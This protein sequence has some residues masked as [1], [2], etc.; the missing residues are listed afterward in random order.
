MTLGE[1]IDVKTFTRKQVEK[2]QVP[3][4]RSGVIKQIILSAFRYKPQ[5]FPIFNH[6]HSAN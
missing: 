3:K 5:A 1:V 2:M 6:R 4:I